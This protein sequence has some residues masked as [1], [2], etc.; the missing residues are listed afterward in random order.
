[1]SRRVQQPPRARKP[2][3][4]PD[5]R[6]PP[7]APVPARSPRC[8]VNFYDAREAFTDLEAQALGAVLALAQRTVARRE[9]KVLIRRARASL[10]FL[11]PQTAGG[12]AR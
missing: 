5:A 12:G 8:F 3:R 9:A 10:A 2:S 4:S 7:T 1:L 6:D 11:Y